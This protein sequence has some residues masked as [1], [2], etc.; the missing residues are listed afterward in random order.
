LA[1]GRTVAV[2]V[3]IVALVAVA[4]TAAFLFTPPGSTNTTTSPAPAHTASTTS[5][6]T[7]VSPIVE[8]TIVN[9]S[10]IQKGAPY[11]VPNMITVVIGVNNTVVWTNDDTMFGGVIH[12]VT[13][14]DKSFNSGNINAGDSFKWTFTTP[15][16]YTYYCVYHAWMK[17]TVIVK[18]G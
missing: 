10:G 17:G 16:T 8:V 9:G 5:N 3:V 1:S 2:I 12:T 13:A 18:S 11:F 6:R 14:T 7:S 15:G 4:A